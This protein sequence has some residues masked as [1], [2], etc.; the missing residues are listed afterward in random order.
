MSGI[1]FCAFLVPGIP[2]TL[3]WAHRGWRGETQAIPLYTATISFIWL[4][5]GSIFP[6]ALGGYYSKLRFTLILLNV[7]TLLLC[8]AFA[9]RKVKVAHY[10]SRRQQAPTRTPEQR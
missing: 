4:I 7:L 8:A 1:V 5:A 2:L 10:P 3:S 6:G 9:N